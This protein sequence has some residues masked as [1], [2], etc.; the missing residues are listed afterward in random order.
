MQETDRKKVPST[1]SLCRPV[2][3]MY[4]SQSS[5]S[6]S[7]RRPLPHN[8]SQNADA[9]L[10]QQIDPHCIC[11]LYYVHS[12][13]GSVWTDIT[14]TRINGRSSFFGAHLGV[15]ASVGHFNLLLPLF[16]RLINARPHTLATQTV[17]R[18]NSGS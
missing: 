9:T 12:L 14:Y 4:T 6:R 18:T 3:F 7:I 13:D 5:S 8:S 1:F 11:F 15:F 17:E 2:P 10:A 16:N